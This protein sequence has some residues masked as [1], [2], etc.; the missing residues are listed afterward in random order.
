MIEVSVV[1]PTEVEQREA[2]LR[3]LIAR[4]DETVPGQ[5]TWEY[6]RDEVEAENLDLWVAQEGK[7]VLMLVACRREDLPGGR[8][9]YDVLM[10][11][12]GHLEHVFHRMM[13]EFD[14]YARANGATT[15]VPIGRP[16]WKKLMRDRGMKIT[17][18]TY[19]AAR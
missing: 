14:A 3:P 19:E 7:H 2:I 9:Y 6:V 1:P 13:D 18:Y 8:R 12:G 17:G 10:A 16:G 4:M 5:W 11:S 15:R